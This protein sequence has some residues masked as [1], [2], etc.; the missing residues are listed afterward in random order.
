M[1]EEVVRSPDEFEALLSEGSLSGRLVQELNLSGTAMD[2]AKMS[3]VAFRRVGMHQ[4]DASSSELSRVRFSE[5]SM[6]GAV[7][8][9][10]RMR[11]CSLFSSELIEARFEHATLTAT[12]FFG[13]GM[14]N[15]TFEGA[16]LQSVSFEGCELFAANFAR[17]LL[18]NTRFVASERGQVPLDRADLSHSIL[19][20]CDLQGANLF[21]ARF[22]HALLVKVDLR[23]ANLAGATFEGARLIDVAVDTSLLEPEQARAIEAAR[24]QDP[25]RDPSLMSAVLAMHGEGE[26]S[27]IVDALLRT[28]VIEGGQASAPL[29]SFPAVLAQL[30]SQYDFSELDHLRVNGTTVEARVGGQW[31]ALG[32]ASVTAAPAPVPESATTD[33]EPPRALPAEPT[34]SLPEPG[35]PQT[36]QEEPNAS[37]PAAPKNVSTSK[38]F[39]RLEMD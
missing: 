1:S 31:H 30:Y 33:P 23:H 25:W 15:A 9:G 18:M 4:S 12:Q 28:Y 29:D 34:A 8:S 7:F 3:D 35:L 36:P 10:G 17:T 16:R 38:R 19:V 22:D 2:N 27:G 26:L 24:V 6:R 11:A 21:S 14:G 5:S 32:G 20:D 13:C 37:E 39:R